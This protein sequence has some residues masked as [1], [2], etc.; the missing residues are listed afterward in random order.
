MDRKRA[1]AGTRPA[2]CLSSDHT[3]EFTFTG[4]ERST[5]M[6]TNLITR[7]VL[8]RTVCVFLASCIVSATLAVGSIGGVQAFERNA[9]AQLA[10]QEIRHG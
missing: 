8:E 10:M 4:F 3:S 9:L 7:T 5:T 2:I 1:A 6:F